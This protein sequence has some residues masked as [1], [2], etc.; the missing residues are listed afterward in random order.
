L[1]VQIAY[2]VT[3]TP[4]TRTRPM[5]GL[6]GGGKEWPNIWSFPELAAMIGVAAEVADGLDYAH[7]HGV[8]HRDIKPDNVLFHD[9][10][11]LVADFGSAL[12][13]GGI[14]WITAGGVSP[15]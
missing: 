13:R 4:A 14:A 12:Q 1:N 7:R 11:G 15:C 8:I 6:R 9:G 5:G 3:A 10:R 2:K